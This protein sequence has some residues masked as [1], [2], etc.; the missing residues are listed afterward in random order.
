METPDDFFTP[1]AP[2]TGGS[3]TQAKPEFHIDSEKAASWLLSKLRAIEDEKA[4]IEDATRQRL[5]ELTADY[6]R[7]MNRFGSELENWARGERETRR[8]KTIT[9]PLAG[10]SLAF[11]TVPARVDLADTAAEIATTLGFIKAPTPDL[12]AFRK[13]AEAQLKE[14]GELIPGATLREA[15]ERFYIKTPRSKKEE[16]PSE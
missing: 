2:G 12:S 8:R 7:L 6:N 9:L 10:A 16:A 15:E 4:A 14:T 13:H 11:R 1:S 3:E 5:D